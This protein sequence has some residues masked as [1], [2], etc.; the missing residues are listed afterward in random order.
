MNAKTLQKI[1]NN[2]LDIICTIDETG[3]FVW[4]NDASLPI[5]GFTPDELVGKLF[6][7]FVIPDDHEKTIKAQKDILNGVK[8]RDFENTYWRKDGTVIPLL[9]SVQ[10]VEDEKLF[11]C[12]A[13]DNTDQNKLRELL[14]AATKMARIGSWEVDLVNDTVYWSDI[15]RQ[16]YEIDEHF[17]PTLEKGISYYR[18]DYREF[19]TEQVMNCIQ[20]GIPFDF[21]VP[22]ITA[23]GNLRWVRAIGK[24][25]FKN[26]KCVRIFGSYQDINDRKIT[27]LRLQN[28]ADNIPGA[29]FQFILKPDGSDKLQN[30]T[31]GSIDLWGMEPEECMA[32][33]S[34]VWQ[35]FKDGGDYVKV[36]ESMHMSA[37]TLKPWFCQWRS[38]RPDGK[39]RWHEGNGRPQILADGSVLWD[40][41]ITDITEKKL[42]EA[43]LRELNKELAER[44]RQLAIS[45]SDLEQFAY[46]A[47][48]DLQEP[49]RMVTSFLAQLE[50]RF[51]A[52]LDDKAKQYIHFAVDGA[53]RMRQ[54]I[55]DLLD[56]SRAGSISEEKTDVNL[57]EIVQNAWELQWNLVKKL[58][59]K[60]EFD[61]LPV[62]RTHITPIKQVLQNLINNA[63]KYSRAGI[64]PEIVIKANDQPDEWVIS[65][66]D[67]GIGI[68]RDY[69]DKIF[70]IFQ[71]LHSQDEYDGSG[72]GL[73]VVKKIV[74]NQGG[75]IWLES[76]P[77]KGSTFY[78]TIRK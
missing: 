44:A 68:E 41:V 8:L 40:S 35:Q 54:I 29:L 65:V 52:D 73:A 58:N 51:G 47:S 43:E 36:I 31:K 28:T 78:F 49:L 62:V 2:T 6:L 11:Y 20:N 22:L 46:V 63:I 57:H 60:I 42:A 45:N 76:S 23:K 21:E 5:L 15:T 3:K 34:K 72:I 59:A 33:T 74:E 9:W 55:L 48:H 67:N 50:K 18:E 25:E 12:V 19:V 13:K 27:E 70:V 61:G 38:L 1:L 77:G 32:D 37:Q 64:P 75:R 26:G 4:L 14:D 17:N 10:W 69:F 66:Q 56:Y 7:D 53:Q 24:P 39:L 16:I 30:L 71:R